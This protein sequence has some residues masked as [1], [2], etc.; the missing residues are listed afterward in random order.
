MEDFA[1]DS[2]EECK[3][4]KPYITNERHN[5]RTGNTNEF[6]LRNKHELSNYLLE[7]NHLHTNGKNCDT[8]INQEGIRIIDL[9]KSFDLMI[10]NGRTNGDY[11]GNFTHYKIRVHQP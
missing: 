9:C 11:W 1:L 8:L 3:K 2:L 5:A 7:D 4:R 6:P 10:L